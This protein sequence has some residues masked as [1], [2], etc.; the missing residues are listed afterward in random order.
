MINLQEIFERSKQN[1][2]FNEFDRVLIIDGLNTWIR[3]AASIA[4]VNDNG[5]HVGGITG[6]LMSI[7]SNIREF[8]P[9]KCIVV[10]DGKGGSLRRRKVFAEYKANRTGKFKPKQLD[11][12]ELNDDDAKESLKWQL[13]RTI[14]Y[15]N[16]LPVQ[17]ICLD[18]IEAD[19]TIAF[20]C[21]QH[22]EDH[23][24]KIRI[25]STDRDFLQLLSDQIE[26]YS[27]V[28]KVLYHQS[29]IKSELNIH[30]NNYLLYRVLTGDNSDNIPGVDGLG[31][32]TILKCF[33]EFSNQEL[34]YDDI[35]EICEEKVKHKKPLKIYQTILDSKDQLDI[36]H[37]LM[38]LAATD[39]SL[40]SKIKI[41]DIINEP[42]MKLDKQKFKQL[43]FEDGLK[44]KNVD[45]WLY[46]SFNG[47]NVWA[48]T[49]ENMD[50]T[51]K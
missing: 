15:L 19:D 27:P 37:Q 9:S 45:N 38:Q 30:P 39:I 42:I 32:K 24:N 17:I 20:A 11:G 47:L 49:S 2:S 13:Q 21:K 23:S 3:V 26:V 10:F 1:H 29:T 8:R 7:A 4:I 16:A 48:I 46:D 33:P 51:F 28:K 44:I 12:Y 43:A 18:N 36:N 31:L 6:F 14:N 25:V 5:M 50:T 40:N 22:Y 35:F 34:T 41:S